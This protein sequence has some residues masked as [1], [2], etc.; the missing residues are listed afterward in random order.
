VHYQALNINV[1]KLVDRI[2]RPTEELGNGL[3]RM[4]ALNKVA[5]A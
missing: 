2:G 4:A 3:I 5:N 1:A